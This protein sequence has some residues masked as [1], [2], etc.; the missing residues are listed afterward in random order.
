MGADRAIQL[1]ADYGQV[2]RVYGPGGARL[3]VV[4]GKRRNY[5]RS[6]A[7]GADRNNLRSLDECVMVP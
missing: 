7:D 4:H 5:L 2:F 3:R 6:V 1:I